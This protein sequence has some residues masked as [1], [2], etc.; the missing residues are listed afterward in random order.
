MSASIVRVSG[1]CAPLRSPPQLEKTNPVSGT[2]V[3][4]TTVP[5]SC[6]PP[7][8]FC[9][10]EPPAPADTDSVNCS[11]NE[12]LTVLSPSTSSVVGLVL[13]DRA[14]P[15]ASNRWPVSGTAV[16]VTVVPDR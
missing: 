3:S 11:T 10:T 2:G 5:A 15:Q 4:V 6:V 7:G 14:P 9:V 16:T 8:G 12:A 1:S 13:P